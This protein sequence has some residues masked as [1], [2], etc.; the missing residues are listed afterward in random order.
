MEK[1]MK[2]F[3]VAELTLIN[4]AINDG[5]MT[6]DAYPFRKFKIRQVKFMKTWCCGKFL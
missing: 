2:H 1:Q 6:A 3:T 4:E 5:Y